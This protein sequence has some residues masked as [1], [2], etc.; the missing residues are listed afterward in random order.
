MPLSLGPNKRPRLPLKLIWQGGGF[1]KGSPLPQE[2]EPAV[3]GS[4]ILAWPNRRMFAG[5]GFSPG[6]PSGPRRCRAVQGGL[7]QWQP[8]VLG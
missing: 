3:V 2:T 7:A 1:W 5:P 4:L 8:W 6:H